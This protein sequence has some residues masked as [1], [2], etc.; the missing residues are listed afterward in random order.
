MQIALVILHA[1]PKRGGAERY[2]ADLAGALAKR[3]HTVSLLA[4]SFA[5]V[6]PQVK[7]V[8]LEARGLTRSQR[9]HAMLDALDAR[10]ET[11]RYDIVHAMLPVRRC[12][13]YHPH[14]GMA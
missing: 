11:A 12:D 9:Y 8:E 1:D 13:V 6:P 5:D 3:G 7:V 14:A 2:T 10:L 4:T